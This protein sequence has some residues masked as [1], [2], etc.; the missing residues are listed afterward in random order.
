MRSTFFF[1]PALRMRQIN[2]EG[3]ENDIAVNLR[4]TRDS[5]D[6]LPFKR[7]ARYGYLIGFGV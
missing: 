2:G 6:T 4:A 3:Q 7:T 1:G 5:S